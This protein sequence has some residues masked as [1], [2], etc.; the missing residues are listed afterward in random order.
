MVPNGPHFSGERT[1]PRVLRPSGS[2]LRRLAAMPWSGNNQRARRPQPGWLCYKA[3]E[4]RF[5]F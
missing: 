2:D 4:K 5:Y 3:L 1:R